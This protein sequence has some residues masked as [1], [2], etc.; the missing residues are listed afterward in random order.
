MR[1]FSPSIHEA[2]L[3]YQH[4]RSGKSSS[5]HCFAIGVEKNYSRIRQNRK[6]KII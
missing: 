1:Q 2:K 3:S 4:K 5:K 6:Q